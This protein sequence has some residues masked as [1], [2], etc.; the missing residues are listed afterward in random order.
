[1][2]SGVLRFLRPGPFARNRG[3]VAHTSIKT[4]QLI[5]P[6]DELNT[7]ENILKGLEIIDGLIAKL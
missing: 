2:R 6:A 1:M 4:Q 3:E 7:V 5:N